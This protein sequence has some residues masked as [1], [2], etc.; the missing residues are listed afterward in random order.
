M[1]IVIGLFGHLPNAD[2]AIQ[3]LN[4]RGL[5]DTEISVLTRQEALYDELSGAY[6]PVIAPAL[7]K[8]GRALA[9]LGGLL[10][11]SSAVSL[12]GIG[13]VLSTGTLTATIDTSLTGARWGAAGGGLMGILR[14]MG[15]SRDEAE[16]YAEGVKRGGI[17]VVVRADRGQVSETQETMRAEGSLDAQ[18]CAREWRQS[19]WQYFDEK[20]MPDDDYWPL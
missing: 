10:I 5:S 14:G 13:P 7:K 9:N 20:T 17:L 18:V 4:A 8:R 1:A 2:R 6:R 16:V 11:E 15:V 3:Q 12:P 19:G